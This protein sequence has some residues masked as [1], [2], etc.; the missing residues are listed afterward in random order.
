[1]DILTLSSFYYLIQTLPNH[2]LHLSGC[3][4]TV[5][6][7]LRVHPAASV[8]CHVINKHQ[9]PS[10]SRARPNHHTASAG[11]SR[12]CELF[13]ILFFC[14]HSGRGFMCPKH[15]CPKLCLLFNK[16]QSSLPIREAY[17]WPAANPLYL[18]SYSLYGR[19][20]N[21]YACLLESVVH[22][23]HCCD[24]VSLHHGNDSC[25]NF[26]DWLFLFLQFLK[27]ELHAH[28]LCRKNKTCKHNTKDVVCSP[29]SSASTLRI[30]RDLRAK[31]A[32]DG[33]LGRSH[34]SEAQ[35]SSETCTGKHFILQ[36]RDIY[37]LIHTEKWKWWICWMETYWKCKLDDQF[38]FVT[39]VSL[40]IIP[41]FV[42][43]TRTSLMC[44]ILM[45][46]DHHSQAGICAQLSPQPYLSGI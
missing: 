19:L 36:C 33:L 42:W 45:F 2:W 34:W 41:V 43:F 4:Q 28:V 7:H 13:H 37:F 25:S 18:P 35:Q 46:T 5:S 3:E 24:D 27:I 16:V 29:L 8:R 40:N 23:V 22:L 1:M 32:Q 20:W 21:W 15:V 17:E 31:L 14:H 44:L 26:S 6:K 12:W 10:G 39:A 11:F 9:C 38:D 30:P